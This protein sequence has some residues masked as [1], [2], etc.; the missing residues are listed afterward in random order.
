MILSLRRAETIVEIAFEDLLK[1]ELRYLQ[2][3]CALPQLLN[4]RLPC[5]T[6]HQIAH[7]LL[8]NPLLNVVVA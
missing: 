3:S 2:P 7:L 1:L 8:I 5:K 6:P 4:V